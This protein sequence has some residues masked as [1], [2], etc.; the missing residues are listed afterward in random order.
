[1]KLHMDTKLIE[2]ISVKSVIF[3]QRVFGRQ[4]NKLIG[5]KVTQSRMLCYYLTQRGSRNFMK[6][7]NVKCNILES[8]DFTN[9]KTF[10]EIKTTIEKFYCF[11]IIRVYSK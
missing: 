5:N 10:M 2:D 3:R 7:G 9:M 4:M 8:M 6:E 11:K 1:M